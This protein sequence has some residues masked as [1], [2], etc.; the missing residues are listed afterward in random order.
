ML[1]PFC[2]SGTTLAVALNHGRKCIGID[3]RENQCELSHRRVG[4][5]KEKHAIEDHPEPLFLNLEY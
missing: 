2:G 3:I 1:D 5:T 4:E